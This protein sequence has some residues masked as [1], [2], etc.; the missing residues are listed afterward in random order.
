MQLKWCIKCFSFYKIFKQRRMIQDLYFHEKNNLF[1]PSN[2]VKNF[3]FPVFYV[4]KTPKMSFEKKECFMLFFMLIIFWITCD[5]QHLIT[6]QKIS[7]RR[8]YNKY[9]KR[10]L[11][12]HLHSNGLSQKIKKKDEWVFDGCVHL[13]NMCLQIPIW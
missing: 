8:L 11:V 7:L 1:F 10:T 12:N 4:P 9:I 3:C 2:G 5:Q 6:T 13:L